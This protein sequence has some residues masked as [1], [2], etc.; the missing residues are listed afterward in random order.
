MWVD[1]I[2]TRDRDKSL[3]E[4]EVN[5]K[6]PGNGLAYL[7]FKSE[8]GFWSFGNIQVTPAVEVG[9]SPDEIIIDAPNNVLTNTENDFKI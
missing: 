6:V 9:F 4:R 7:R 1:N 3:Y 5:F 2:K 8:D